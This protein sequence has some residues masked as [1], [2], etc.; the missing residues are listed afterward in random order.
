MQYIES[1]SPQQC[2]PKLI[3]SSNL[4]HVK[5]FEHFEFFPVALARCMSWTCLGCFQLR[6]DSSHLLDF[7]L[8]LLSLSEHNSYDHN[9]ADCVGKLPLSWGIV[10]DGNQA[11]IYSNER[12]IKNCLSLKHFD[13]ISLY[14][15]LNEGEYGGRLC[16]YINQSYIYMIG[17]LDC[18]DTY[19]M[20]CTLSPSCSV[21]I[22]TEERH[23][24]DM[25]ILI[26][27]N[28][29]YTEVDEVQDMSRK[30]NEQVLP[31]VTV[32]CSPSGNRD[33]VE[34]VYDAATSKE[35]GIGDVVIA[36]HKVPT[37]PVPV[38]YFFPSSSQRSL[39]AP[40][41]QAST[42]SQGGAAIVSAMECCVCLSQARSVLFL[43]CKHL[44]T[45]DTC[46]G[47]PEPEQSIQQQTR[48]RMGHCPMCRVRIKSRI[49][50]YM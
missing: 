11:S 25:A 26:N 29:D 39:L 27:S 50:V 31:H 37:A 40:S 48:K 38:P 28:I 23:L 16:I 15:D 21:G 43:P 24:H 35:T 1:W 34:E 7:S 36:S 45:C 22:Y 2:H 8:G 13:V 44:C 17:G 20:A 41:K 47:E 12:K 32:F 46:G 49:K 9:L 18:E 30:E 14:L 3:I 5:R 4:A 10:Q 33:R 6:I 19:A 42:K